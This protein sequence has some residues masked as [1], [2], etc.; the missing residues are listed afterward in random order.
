MSASRGPRTS[1]DPWAWGSAPLRPTRTPEPLSRAPFKAPS[2]TPRSPSPEGSC[3]PVQGSERS[4]A[5]LAQRTGTSRNRHYVK[6]APVLGLVLRVRTGALAFLQPDPQ[7]HVSSQPRG[8]LLVLENGSDRMTEPSQ[9]SGKSAA[10]PRTGT[11][12]NLKAERARGRG[13]ISIL[14]GGAFSRC[15]ARVSSGGDF[16]LSGVSGGE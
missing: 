6:L 14:G 10:R 15:L 3:A 4:G 13:V 12:A 8:F 16:S 1:V 7:K 2:L 5:L 11:G 9:H